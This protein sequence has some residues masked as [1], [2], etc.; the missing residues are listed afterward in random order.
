M[1]LRIIVIGISFMFPH[2]KQTAT[3][4]QTLLLA[5]MADSL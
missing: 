4:V 3:I 1:A 2:V 5:Q